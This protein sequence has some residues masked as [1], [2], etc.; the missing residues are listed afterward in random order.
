MADYRPLWKGKWHLRLLGS[1]GREI[2][3]QEE[4]PESL[5]PFNDWRRKLTFKAEL[6]GLGCRHYHVELVRGRRRDVSPKPYLKYRI[7]RNMGF[8][9]SL[10]AGGGR[11]C[12]AGPL[13]LPLVVEDR[14]DSW[15][16][17]C[18]SYRKV[19]GRFKPLKRSL[20]VIRKGPVR[21]LTEAVYSW[22][23]S[24]IAAQIYAYA[25]WP[26]LELRLRILWNEEHR[27]LKLAVPTVFHAAQVL[28]EVPGGA[29]FRPADGEE[30][31]QGRWLLLQG[32][33]K[34]KETA[35]A[36]VNS[37][38]HGF[39]FL[40]G[41]VRLSILRSAAYCH[42]RGFSLDKT[43]VLKCM[44]QG[45]HDVR[46]LVTAGNLDEVRASVSGLADW[47]SAPP[48]AYAHLPFGSPESVGQRPQGEKRPGF[49]E[50]F[51]LRPASIRLAAC[52]RSGDG[53][54]LIVRLHET[55]GVAANFELKLLFPAQ[56]IGLSFKPFEIKTLRI[57]KNGEWREADSVDEK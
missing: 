22:G 46:L 5:L 52:K 47:L 39:D 50:V 15:G 35:L 18:R 16:T 57:E 44:D 17:G 26:V 33:I 51:S 13:F 6:P 48:V 36:I 12:L 55:A 21:T 7:D 37:G 42:E 54:A 49:L 53:E 3:C 41:E 40:K 11:E 27:R 32:R 20:R 9:T 1:D 29:I 56:D 23:K 31:V 8:I 34:N 25:C 4:Q 45:V 38:Q 28:C 43:P 30:H 14:G 10:D 2:P 19:A 24:R